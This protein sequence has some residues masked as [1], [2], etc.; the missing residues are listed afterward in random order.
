MGNYKDFMI[1]AIQVSFQSMEKS[2]FLPCLTDSGFVALMLMSIGLGF[3]VSFLYKYIKKDMIEFIESSIS[4]TLVS[5][6]QGWPADF[7]LGIDKVT[8]CTLI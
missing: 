8:H 2:G 5:F 3:R 6:C 1:E 4:A 7:C